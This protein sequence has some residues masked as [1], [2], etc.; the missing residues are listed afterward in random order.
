MKISVRIRRDGV[1][2]ESYVMSMC[3][4][5]DAC[6][7]SRRQFSLCKDS[8]IGYWSSFC[9]AAS[10]SVGPADILGTFFIEQIIAVTKLQIPKGSI[11]T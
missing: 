3:E 8:V 10:A 1:A 7:I 5:Q 4:Q 2:C 6:S 11:K 9:G